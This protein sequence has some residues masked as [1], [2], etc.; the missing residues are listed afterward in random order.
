[1]FRSGFLPRALGVLMAIA[2]LGYG[3]NGLGN[4]LAP[5]SAPIFAAI[6]GVT[7]LTGEVPLV[8]W[9]L[10]KGV[11]EARWRDAH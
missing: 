9:L 8:L 2:S 10:V 7:A 6:V 5:E 4:L 3:L 11:D 1:V